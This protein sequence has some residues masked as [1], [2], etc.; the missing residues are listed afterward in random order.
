MGCAQNSK[1]QTGYCIILNTIDLPAVLHLQNV[2]RVLFGYRHGLDHCVSY[3]FLQLMLDF[4][5]L[6]KLRYLRW[7]VCPFSFCCK[8]PSAGRHRGHMSQEE[9]DDL[10]YPSIP[11]HWTKEWMLQQLELEKVDPRVNP[12]LLLEETSQERRDMCADGQLLGV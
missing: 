9:F 2:Q 11:S 12:N 10:G 7:M 8:R 5:V 4:C 6:V 1:W 3:L